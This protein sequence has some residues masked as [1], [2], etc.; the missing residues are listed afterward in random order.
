MFKFLKRLRREENSSETAP[1]TPIEG[2]STSGGQHHHN[3][4]SIVK[5]LKKTLSSHQHHQVFLI[6]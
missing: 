1:L 6:N 3:Y 5:L 2:P 4:G